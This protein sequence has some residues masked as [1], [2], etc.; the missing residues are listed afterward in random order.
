[1]YI[2]V[3]NIAK[4]VILLTTIMLLAGTRYA[5]AQ[6][7]PGNPYY[8]SQHKY[9]V[10]N[11]VSPVYDWYIF[12]TEAA[13]NS[14]TEG[15]ALL[16]TLDYVDGIDLVSGTA[17]VEIYYDK[18]VFND[19]EVFLVF[20]EYSQLTGVCIARRIFPITIIDNT[21]YFSAGADLENCHP[22]EGEV[23]NWNDY[24]GQ[25][26]EVTYDFTIT[27]HKAGNFNIN[28]YTFEGKISLGD[29][30]YDLVSITVPGSISSDLNTAN[31]D[32]SV[33]MNN[34][35]Y[36][37]NNASEITQDIT[38][39]VTVTGLIY[40]SENIIVRLTRGQ[41]ESGLNYTITTNEESPPPSGTNRD[42]Q[43]TILPLPATPNI[44]IVN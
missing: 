2:W 7:T 24:N 4:L 20:S 36:I 31:G 21:F 30:N 34:A 35:T 28:N 27:L 18:E 33:T 14:F 17:T 39:E 42:Q 26:Y 3:R 11:V 8:L 15:T 22:L 16:N 25:N 5:Y 10:D 41:A 23:L 40:E 13:A 38:L 19:T 9:Q 29:D 43:I 1:M 37:E 6:N 32:F 44:A 12:E